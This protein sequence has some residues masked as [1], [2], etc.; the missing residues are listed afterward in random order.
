VS[1]V[2]VIAARSAGAHAE[3]AG[4]DR[5]RTR[6]QTPEAAKYLCVHQVTIRRWAREG[7]IPS[8]KLGHGAASGSGETIS[9]GARI[10]GTA[11]VPVSAGDVAA[12]RSL[13]RPLPKR[14]GVW[15]GGLHCS[16]MVDPDG[17]LRPEMLPLEVWTREGE[18]LIFHKYRTTR[19]HSLS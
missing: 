14:H 5:Q 6:I 17:R 16:Q 12:E 8:G 3:N 15:P 2:T 4:L 10:R 13:G 11:T 9:T 7:A 18:H 1:E 19:D